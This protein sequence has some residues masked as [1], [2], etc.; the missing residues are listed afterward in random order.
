M[1]VAGFSDKGPVRKSNQDRYDIALNIS[2]DIKACLVVAD[3]MGGHSGGEIASATAVN[4]VVKFITKNHAEYGMAYKR[5]IN[6]AINQ[7]N[8]SIYKRAQK[9]SDLSG[10]GTTLVICLVLYDELLIA[11]I[12][13]S[14]AY[15]FFGG[16]IHKITND[17]SMVEELISLGQITRKQAEEHP[18]RNVITRAVGT[19]KAVKPDYFSIPYKKDDILLLCSDGVT[20]MVEEDELVNIVSM[21]EPLEK[22]AKGIVEL[23]NYN[24]GKDNSTVIIAR[25]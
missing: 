25:L 7:A 22:T 12:G 18:Y 14:R 4:M 15:T 19:Q 5:M 9:E 24:G 20:N 23:A 1:Q 6:D 21:G 16:A 8:T 13:D 10:M 11:N 17:H 3:G 2:G